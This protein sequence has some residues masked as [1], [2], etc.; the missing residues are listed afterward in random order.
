MP[1]LSAHVIPAQACGE[2]GIYGQ[3]ASRHLW[4]RF[5]LLCSAIRKEEDRLSHTLGIVFLRSTFAQPYPLSM[6]RA[7]EGRRKGEGR[8]KEERGKSEGNACGEA[9]FLGHHP[10]GFEEIGIICIFARSTLFYPWTFIPYP[11]KT[12]NCAL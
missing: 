8:A 12:S 11:K 2:A 10:I 6:A 9:F 7:K 1:N 3:K 4:L 5:C